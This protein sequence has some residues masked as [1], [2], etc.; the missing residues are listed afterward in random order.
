MKIILLCPSPEK[1]EGHRA[2]KEDYFTGFTWTNEGA[3][4]IPSG[5]SINPVNLSER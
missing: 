3:M 5:D 1:G 4:S 2:I